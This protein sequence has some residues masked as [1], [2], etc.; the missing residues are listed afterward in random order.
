MSPDLVMI[1]EGREKE[2]VLNFYTGNIP[3]F[4]CK[5]SLDTLL[6]LQRQ[7]IKNKIINKRK[8]ERDKFLKYLSIL[9]CIFPL[10]PLKNIEI[11]P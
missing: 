8:E 3:L 2:W 11:T 1:N 7:E 10:K 6:I 5:S 4:P 9:V